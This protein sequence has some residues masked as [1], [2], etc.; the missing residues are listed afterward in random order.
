MP[1]AHAAVTG[2]TAAATAATAA[3]TTSAST[4]ARD[5]DRGHQD[6]CQDDEKPAHSTLLCVFHVSVCMTCMCVRR[7][8]VARVFPEQ[9]IPGFA[10]S[11]A[12]HELLIVRTCPRRHDMSNDIAKNFRPNL[13]CAVQAR[14]RAARNSLLIFAMRLSG[15]CAPL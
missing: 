9:E 8:C 4:T 15:L 7:I 2:T 13:N 6:N 11:C 1:Y 12:R 3:A 10:E 5:G 14:A